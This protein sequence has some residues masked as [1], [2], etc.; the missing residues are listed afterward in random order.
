MEFTPKEIEDY[1]KQF[2]TEESKILLDLSKRTW[3]SE[4]SPQMISGS[5]IGGLLQMLIKISGSKNILEIGM[6]TGYSA[7]KMAEVLPED[8]R[9]HT[10]E[11][12]PEYIKTAKKWFEKSS[13][14][15][16]IFI[17]E[18]KALESLKKFNPG[19]FDFF[20]IDADKENYPRY[21]EQSLNLLK[22]E[23][24]GVL[25]NMLWSG[26]VLTPKDPDSIAIRETA[27]IIKNNPN[28]EPLLLPVRDGVM[29][30]RKI[31]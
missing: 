16:K 5:L 30:F 17:H 6:F 2:S 25:D 31:K 27:K 14:K 8:G 3:E 29:I 1:C 11:L 10:C 19:S 12:N 23:G 20:F 21:L 28:L 22:V 7:L 9:M 4:E 26:K 18:G 13:A 24:I 15:N